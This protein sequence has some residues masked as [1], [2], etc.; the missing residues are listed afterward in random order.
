MDMDSELLRAARHH[1]DLSQLEA[2]EL[3]KVSIVTYQ[4]WE[5]G[6]AKPQPYH[7][8]QI[9]SVFGKAF[10]PLALLPE[11]EVF[12]DLSSEDEN[13][14]SHEQGTSPQILDTAPVSNSASIALF[15]PIPA[16][17]EETERALPNEPEVF[18]ATHMV[19]HL[20]SLAFM[21]HATSEEKRSAIRQAIKEF[22]SM[23]TSNKNYQITRREALCSLATLPMITLGLSTSGKRVQP[24]QYKIVLEQCAA[25]IEAC[26][27]LSKSS[28]SGDLLLAF[29]MISQYLSTLK[30]IVKESSAHSR[31]A[32]SLTAQAYLLKHV[33]G[34]HVESPDVAIAKGYAKL[35]VIY[36]EQSHDPLLHIT[37]LRNLTWAYNHIRNY[38]QALSTIEQAEQLV[39]CYRTSLPSA[40]ICAA[41][42]TLAVIKAKNGLSPAPALDHAQMALSELPTTNHAS[43]SMDFSYAKLM[44]DNALAYY[45]QGNYGEALAALANVIDSNDL[46]SK[47]PMPFRTRVELLNNQTMSML[48]SSTKDMDQ[49]LHCWRA[50]IEGAINL[51][52][53]QRFDEACMAYEV[54]SGIWPRENSIKDLRDLVVH[55]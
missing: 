38:S 43:G 53:Q 35:A 8:R 29:K 42:S 40:G 54:M 22:D 3:L 19:T 24:A 26:W 12:A 32:T 41:Y 4:R 20:W 30:T 51:R 17:S 37:A 46:S 47:V 28:E 33:L 10:P 14:A 6:K 11:E 50:G 39:E 23:N 49:V 27:E 13:V 5:Q 52:S 16:F 48:K 45:Y 1:F 55:W 15:P 9:R 18:I 21:E 2:A 7:R 44:R 31:D 34:L 36:A 25:S